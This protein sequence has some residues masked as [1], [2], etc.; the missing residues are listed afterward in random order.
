MSADVVARSPSAALRA[1][2]PHPI[3]DADAHVLEG[4]FVLRDF[5]KQVGGPRLLERFEETRKTK[6]TT[7]HRRMFWAAPSGKYTLDRATAMLPKLYR[8]RLGEAGVDFAVV[9]T[10]YGLDV[11]QMQD[12]ELRPVVARSLNMMYAEMFKDVG[13]RVTPSALIPMH[14]PEEAIRELEFAVMELGFKSITIS[15]EVRRPVPEVLREAPHLARL[16]QRIYSLT[17]DSPR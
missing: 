14:T 12:D 5:I 3:V 16:T 7:P 4:E 8:E 11:M 1:K 17:I 15:A 13:D 6:R 10:T 9:Y 2:L